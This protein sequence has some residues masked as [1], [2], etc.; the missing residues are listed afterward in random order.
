MISGAPGATAPKRHGR[1]THTGTIYYWAIVV[2]FAIATAMA[3]IR[4]CVCRKCHP[5]R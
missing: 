4:P 1:H 2:V 3:A 5:P